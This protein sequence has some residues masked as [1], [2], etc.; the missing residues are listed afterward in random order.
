MSVLELDV[1]IAVLLALVVGILSVAGVGDTKLSIAAVLF[2]IAVQSTVLVRLRLDLREATTARRA[3]ESAL[4]DLADAVSRSGSSLCLDYPDFSKEIRRALE[5]H[6]VAGASLRTTVGAFLRKMESAVGRGTTMK[7]MCPDPRKTGLMRQLATI[8]GRKV[9]DVTAGIKSNLN[10]AARLRKEV[11][12]S[13]VGIRVCSFLP[14][15]GLVLFDS[16]PTEPAIMYVKLLPFGQTSGYAP[17]L[18]L[19]S[20]ED[21]EPFEIL[22]ESIRVTWDSAQDWEAA[23]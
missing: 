8:Q 4:A 6:V 20:H 12:K 9:N 22:A 23:N 11:N 19:T 14:S 5:I 13:T 1:T 21:S 10:L 7:L 15:L 16:R 18:R 17:V 2:L 3:L